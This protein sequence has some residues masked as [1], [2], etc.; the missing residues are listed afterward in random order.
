M[1]VDTVNSHMAFSNSLHRGT[2][3]SCH[4]SASSPSSSPSP[5]LCSL[6]DAAAAAAVRLVRPAVP[7][8]GRK[9]RLSRS[10]QP[11]KPLSPEA[12]RQKN[13]DAQRA[14]RDRVS[15][16][17]A[18][19]ESEVTRLRVHVKELE[20]E[21][22][23]LK[24]ELF[25][26]RFIRGSAG[27]LSHPGSASVIKL[28]GVE[29]SVDIKPSPD[30]ESITPA[31]SR[32]PSGSPSVATGGNTHTGV[33]CSW[34][35]PP[36]APPAL[37]QLDITS[38]QQQQA[39]VAPPSLADAMRRPSHAEL[40]LGFSVLQ[41]PSIVSPF[42]QSIVRRLSGG[43]QHQQTK[44]FPAGPAPFHVLSH[45]YPSPPTPTSLAACSP[46]LASPA[47]ATATSSSSPLSPFCMTN[48]SPVSTLVSTSPMVTMSPVDGFHHQAYTQ[49]QQ[50]LMSS[51]GM[52]G[53]PHGAPVSSPLVG[54]QQNP[55]YSNVQSFP[56]DSLLR[57]GTEQL[58]VSMSPASSVMT[59]PALPIDGSLT[60]MTP[61][62]SCAS[63]LLGAVDYVANDWRVPSI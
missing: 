41:Q 45:Q 9:K 21:N 18:D 4:S 16:K 51:A 19:L 35:H 57:R 29:S 7:L 17:I 33:G 53:R 8:P 54:H 10:A 48:L 5:S 55:H 38:S 15:R 2:S 47:S 22:G 31:Q 28:D 40:S 6:T 39:A 11:Q 3:S 37:S 32:R 63:S 49:S 50:T 14:H 58:R 61:S 62:T 56:G 44:G 30:V 23:N 26:S 52:F 59:S 60:V 24:E 43:E 34:S 20:E 42:P 12:V 36:T 46:I 27:G 13:R 1:L 25:S